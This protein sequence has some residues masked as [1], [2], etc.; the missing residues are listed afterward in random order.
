[1]RI[2]A[3]TRRGLRLAAVAKGDVSGRLR[4][5][6]DRVR[7]SL[8]N[9]LAGGSYGDAVTDSRVLDLFAGTGALGLEALSRGAAHVSFVERGSTAHSLIQRNVFLMNAGEATRLHRRDA[10]KLGNCPTDPFTLVFLDPPY[11]RDLGRLSLSSALAGGWLAPEA[12]IVWEDSTPQEVPPGFALCEHRC[13]G[14]TH[15]TLAKVAQA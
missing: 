2:V 11:G 3:G 5:T 13:Y 9:V 12:L 8:F 15:I 14:G 7:E 1:M 10:T 6:S 4:P